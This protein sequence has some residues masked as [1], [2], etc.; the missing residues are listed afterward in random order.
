M[1]QVTMTAEEKAQFEAFKAEQEKRT[2]AEQARQNRDAY[3]A[4][5]DETINSMF[6]DLEV[7]SENLTAKKTAVFAVANS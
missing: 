6:P 4:L 7:V 5:V 2:K 1:E 3:K